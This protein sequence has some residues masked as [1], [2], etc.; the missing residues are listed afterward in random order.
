MSKSLL[1][2]FNK[3]LGELDPDWIHTFLPGQLTSEVAHRLNF[4][5]EGAIVFS[6]VDFQEWFVISIDG[7]H[8]VHDS[9]T[10]KLDFTDIRETE[11]IYSIAKDITEVKANTDILKIITVQGKEHVLLCDKQG[12]VFSIKRVIDFG[13]SV[14]N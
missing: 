5:N 1:N 12:A 8:L 7:I 3:K 9:M 4:E 10:T 13:M 2:R 11:I 14:S 6:I